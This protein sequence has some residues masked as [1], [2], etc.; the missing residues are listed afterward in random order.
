MHIR[1]RQLINGFLSFALQ[2]QQYSRECAN[3]VLHIIAY[4]RHAFLLLLML[5]TVGSI[6]DATNN[7]LN[8]ITHLRCVAR[9]ARSEVAEN[10]A[11]ITAITHLRCYRQCAAHHH[12]SSMLPTMCCTPSYIFDA[13]NNVLNIITHLRCVA[14]CRSR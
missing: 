14:R 2:L 11:D 13:T 9:A 12:T 5:H 3:N 1:Y 6:F 4:L 7:V 8:I 10:V